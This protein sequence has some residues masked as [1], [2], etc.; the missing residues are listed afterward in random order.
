MNWHNF[1]KIPLVLWVCGG[2][3][4][5]LALPLS[6]FLVPVNVL[7]SHCMTPIAIGTPG[8]DDEQDLYLNVNLSHEMVSSVEVRHMWFIAN[9]PG[10]Y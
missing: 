5:W 7:I 2:S 1:L 3:F 4:H 10:D 8:E 9:N 6:F